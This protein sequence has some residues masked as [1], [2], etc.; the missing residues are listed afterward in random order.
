MYEESYQMPFLCRYPAKIP[1]GSKSKDIACNVDFASTFLDYAGL[2]IPKH[3]QGVSM[4]KVLEGKTPQNWEQLGYHRYWMHNDEIHEAWAHYGVRDQ[5]YKLIYWYNKDLNQL[6]SRP[7]NA[8]PEWELFDCEADPDE[9]TNLANNEKYK[10]VFITML[11]KLD[12]KMKEIEDTP[13]HDSESVIISLN[14]LFE[15]KSKIQ[16]T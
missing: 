11:A 16:T 9:L 15:K 2:P 8:H 5:R 1:S 14:N 12:K 7:N 10:K 4:R 13:E 6:G 3:M